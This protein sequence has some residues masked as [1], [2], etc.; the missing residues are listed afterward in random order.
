MNISFQLKYIGLNKDEMSV[1]ISLIIDAVG[2]LAQEE[3]V[4]TKWVV[5]PHGPRAGVLNL[6][7]SLPCI[8][9][10]GRLWTLITSEAE[11]SA[12]TNALMPIEWELDLVG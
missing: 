9:F 10:C 11:S 4:N 1:K 3:T 6:V 7:P 5:T 2:P 12:G 8:D